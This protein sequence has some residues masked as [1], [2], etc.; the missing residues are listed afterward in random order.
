MRPYSP[1]R[2]K[3][4]LNIRYRRRIEWFPHQNLVQGK[5]SGNR[6]L[7]ANAHLICVSSVR[8]VLVHCYISYLLEIKTTLFG[9]Q[10]LSKKIKIKYKKTAPLFVLASPSRVRNWNLAFIW[11]FTIFDIFVSRICTFFCRLIIGPMILVKYQNSILALYRCSSDQ[12]WGFLTKPL[13]KW[14]DICL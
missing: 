11:A 6:T 10:N 4:S 13:G 14:L 1:S 8:H 12:T 5:L 7:R 3:K 9:G 2:E